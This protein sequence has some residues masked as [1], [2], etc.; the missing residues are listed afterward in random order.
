MCEDELPEGLK[1]FDKL[2]WKEQAEQLK[3]YLASSDPKPDWVIAA[4]TGENSDGYKP[5]NVLNISPK[6]PEFAKF[7]E[8]VKNF[9]YSTEQ[10]SSSSG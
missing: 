6:K 9:L 3:S 10:E 7:A 2:G 1:G 5:S 4:E 8:L